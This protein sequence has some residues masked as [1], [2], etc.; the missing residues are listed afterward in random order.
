MYKNYSNY[1]LKDQQRV[2]ETSHY[3]I[4]DLTIDVKAPIVIA[5]NKLFQYL[6]LNE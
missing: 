5:Y 2:I 3:H 1:V 6:N 4:R